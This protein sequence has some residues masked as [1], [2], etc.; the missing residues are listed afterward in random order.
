MNK[1]NVSIIIVI[2]FFAFAGFAQAQTDL[3]IEQTVQHHDGECSKDSDCSYLNGYVDGSLHCKDGDIV[4]NYKTYT[5][6]NP[7]T[8]KSDCKMTME[9]RK[10]EECAGTCYEP[11]NRYGIDSQ[12]IGANCFEQEGPRC[13]TCIPEQTQQ[14][15][16]TNVGACEYGVQTCTNDFAWGS[17]VGAINPVTEICDGT[18]NNCDSQT[19][20]GYNIGQTC[21]NELLGACAATG[22]LVC[23]PN[24][25]GSVCN[26][27]LIQGTEEVCGDQ[28]DNDCDGA[29]DEDCFVC[30]R[31][32][33][34]GD[35]I[36]DLCDNCVYIA[37]PDQADTDNDKV[38][39][40]CDNCANVANA[41]QQN[42]DHDGLGNACDNYNCIP[43]GVEVCNERD[44]DCDG[45]RDE[46]DVCNPV[47]YTRSCAA[48]DLCTWDTVLPLGSPD[49]G[50]NCNLQYNTL[51]P[52]NTE[53]TVTCNF[54]KAQFKDYNLY[55]SIDNDVI[56]C[57]L[58]GE[59]VVNTVSHENCAPQDIVASGYNYLLPSL[60]DGSN[61][62]ICHVRDRG[63][64]SFFDA[65]VVGSGELPPPT[66]VCGDGIVNSEIERCDDGNT[67]AGDG[68]SPTC[69]VEKSTIVATKIV[70]NSETDL[71]NW[72][73]GGPDITS[74]TAADFLEEHPNCRLEAGWTFQWGYDNA[75][76]PGDNTGAATEGWHT[77]EPT[78]E[79]G[80]TSATIEM[81]GAQIIKFREVWQNGY[82]PFT[83]ATTNSRTDILLCGV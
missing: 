40:V 33:A 23:S 47:L 15:G 32:D 73:A 24:H 72:G 81:N 62:L 79:N 9:P 64:M 20:E 26:A 48:S 60:K 41:D 83:Y 11:K 51:W 56:D 63:Y 1:L 2:L 42:D 61:Q 45:F 66:P 50:N 5:C 57:T 18:D 10:K 31:T 49:N 21:S 68:C 82:I 8:W 28:I 70:C 74:T 67:V 25:D 53:R 6:D 30:G 43:T 71:P 69:T 46:G 77:I 19:D 36:G 38:G 76:N 52:I 4:G 13:V 35:G 17:C 27:Q 3:T 12:E 37:N 59:M 34:D 80:E 58:N 75:V 14:C 65:C 39:N 29:V 78:N 22:V 16:Q 44:D 55:F 54:N 7:G